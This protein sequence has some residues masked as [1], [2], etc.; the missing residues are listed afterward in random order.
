M[1]LR[2]FAGIKNN[3]Y[4]CQEQLTSIL[5]DGIIQVLWILVLLLQQGALM[6]MPISLSPNGTSTSTS[7]RR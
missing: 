1:E 2:E 3:S 5:Y 6:K 7:K 4:I